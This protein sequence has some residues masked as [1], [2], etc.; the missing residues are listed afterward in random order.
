MER[1]R[2]IADYAGSTCHQKVITLEEYW[3]VLPKVQYHMDEPLADPSAVALWF[4][5]ELA[6][7]QAEGS[8][9]RRRCGRVVWRICGFIMNQ[10]L[11]R[12][13][14]VLPAGLKKKIKEKLEDNKRILRKEL[15]DPRMYTD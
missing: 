6:A 10:S 11:L 9:V 2:E 15:S 8:Y 12:P 14:K 7:K 3:A 13:F 4:V 5:D 1:A